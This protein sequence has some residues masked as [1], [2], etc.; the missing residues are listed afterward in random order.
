V[1][2]KHIVIL[3]LMLLSLGVSLGLPAEDVLDAVYDESE[4]LPF[5]AI[6]LFSTVARPRLCPTPQSVQKL[7]CS[8][9]L[10]SLTRQC[11][12]PAPRVPAHPTSDSLTLLDHSLR[13]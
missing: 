6:S 5:E 2:K 1:A 13:C 4:A 8:F 3:I 9:H 7:D 10:G 11:Q 12:C